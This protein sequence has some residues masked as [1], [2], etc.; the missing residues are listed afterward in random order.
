MIMTRTKPDGVTPLTAHIWE[1]QAEIRQIL[2]QLQRS[3]K[4]V[5]VIVLTM[6]L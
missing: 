3:G 6:I 1:I 4:R 5:G 2:P